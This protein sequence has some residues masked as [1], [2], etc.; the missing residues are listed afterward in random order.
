MITDLNEI[1]VEWAYRT[2][3]GKPDVKNNAKLLT[4]E[5]VLKDFG[6]SREA[7]A[8]LLNTL[9]EIAPTTMVSNPNPKGRAKKVQYRYA[10]Q[11]LDDNPDAETSDDFKK[12]VGQEK[13]DEDEKPKDKKEKA[14]NK[15]ISQEEID[16]IDGKNKTAALNGKEKVPGTS[17]S[18]TNE[19]G[20]G[21]AMACIDESPEDVDGCLDEKLKKTKLGKSSKNNSKSKRV[22]MIQAARREK[23]R[24][25]EAMIKNDMNPKTTKVSHIGGTKGSLN[26]T[27]NHLQNKGVKEVNGI[28]FDG[29]EDKLFRKLPNGEFELDKDGNRIAL[30]VEVDENG[31]PKNYA[32]IILNG[33]GGGDPTDTLVVML[34]EG[35]K[36]PKVVINHTSN[37]MTTK[38][39]Q[40]NSG[41]TVT[42]AKNN[43]AA[44]KG[45]RKED[46]EKADK[47]EKETLDEIENQR[48]AQKDYVKDFTPKL[49]SLA[50]D[51]DVL[52]NIYARFMNGLDGKPKGISDSPGKYAKIALKKAGCDPGLVKNPDANKPKIKECIKKYLDELKDKKSLT[53]EDDQVVTRLLTDETMITGKSPE[54]PVM[55]RSKLNRFYEKQTDALNTQ[56]ERLNELGEKQNPPNPNLGNSVFVDDLIGRMH[57]DIAEGHDPGGIP[58]DNF[59]LI[60]GSYEG[61]GIRQDADGNIYEKG[62]D[63]KYYKIGEDGKP[64]GEGV[65]KNKLQKFDCAVVGNPEVHRECLG[66]KEGE[67]VEEGFD[68]KYEEYK[69][70][71][72]SVS[73]KALIYDRNDK[74]IAVQTVRSKTGPGGKIQ[75]EMKWGD[76]YQD[77]MAKT[78]KKLGY[79]N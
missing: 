41:P 35:S 33:G 43:K 53:G 13:D 44:K 78:T 73:I 18:A 58:N 63:G 22:H 9:M 70:E 62:E 25:N 60:H 71:D 20:T 68:V 17:S 57:L 37:K 38:D 52:D 61:T 14:P 46:H 31:K 51:D 4:L 40:S 3:D 55:T 34:D 75:D 65:L 7:R 27:V 56:R 10:K 26:S 79:C 11:W 45:L 21:Y 66:I 29:D 50:E 1:L 59:E 36:P 32:Q 16:D 77:C 49:S 8:E 69:M 19:I 6:W 48:Q 64:S 42:V 76:E 15:P 2:N 12:D 23:R 74:V 28:P 24:V 5:G 72:G 47:I 54:E 67:K 39:I 30:P